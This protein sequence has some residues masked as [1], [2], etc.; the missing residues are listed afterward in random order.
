MRVDCQ[1]AICSIPTSC[2]SPRESVLSPSL[3]LS[4]SSCHTG[5]DPPV[6]H[7][8]PHILA[9]H[10]LFHAHKSFSSCCTG[11]DVSILQEC[12]HRPACLPGRCAHT[13]FEASFARCAESAH[14]CLPAVTRA[15]DLFEENLA[16]QK[17][18]HFPRSFFTVCCTLTPLL[19][20]Q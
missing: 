5:T 19:S 14:T 9:E 2:A 6:F 11:T 10:V 8:F 12:I 13:S 4:A 16:S 7:R 17:I 3:P 18:L 1:Q 15:H 20:P